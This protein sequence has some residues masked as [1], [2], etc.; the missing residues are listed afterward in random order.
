MD[1]F[2]W[3]PCV[4][5]AVIS[6][7]ARQDLLRPNTKPFTKETSHE[8]GMTF[9]FQIGASVPVGDTFSHAVDYVQYF[10][11]LVERSFWPR[12]MSGGTHKSEYDACPAGIYLLS[13][14]LQTNNIIGVF[15]ARK[16]R[17]AISR[18]NTIAIRS[19]AIRAR[20]AGSLQ[21]NFF[22]RT[23]KESLLRK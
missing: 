4:L 12:W 18:P 21:R 2:P 1:R 19:F 9:L 22:G 20:P 8:P 15:A 17:I 11:S 7:P 14:H 13:L 10:K 16:L 23:G 5:R 3:F 6:I